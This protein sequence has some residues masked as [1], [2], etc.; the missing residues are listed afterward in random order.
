M[1]LEQAIQE[2]TKAMQE[3]AAAL[4][5]QTELLMSIHAGHDSPD[6]R[7]AKAA[8]K[9]TAETSATAEKLTK[10]EEP[11]KEE[12]PANAP[13]GDY[14]RDK[15]KAMTAKAVANGHRDKVVALLKSY[16]ATNASSL[17]EGKISEYCTALEPLQVKEG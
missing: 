3:M 6:E 2:N 15:A 11:K 14:D 4:R 13:S 1:S 16:G 5:A 8:S 17:D 10:K 9:I 12:P 7:A